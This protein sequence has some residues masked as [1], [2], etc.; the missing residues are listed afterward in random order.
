MAQNHLTAHRYFKELETLLLLLSLHLISP[1]IGDCASLY[2]CTEPA[3][4]ETTQGCS[5]GY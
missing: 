3:D 5:F 4:T 2:L 1:K